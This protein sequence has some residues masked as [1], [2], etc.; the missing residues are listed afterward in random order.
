MA[1]NQDKVIEIHLLD[2]LLVITRWRWRI[3]RNILVAAVGIFLLS[4]LMPKK[5]I[6]VTTL[7]P[8]PEQEGSAMASLLSEVKVPGV[9][10]PGKVTFHAR[11]GDRVRIETPGGGGYGREDE[12]ADATIVTDAH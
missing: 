10:L 11:A 2:Y 9:A 8:P 3:L 5:Y 6:A 1:D 12:P 4:F 7:L